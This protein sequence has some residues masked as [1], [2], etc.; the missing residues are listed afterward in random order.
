MNNHYDSYD[1]LL[2]IYLGVTIPP[3]SVN[4]SLNGVAQFTCTGVASAFVWKENGIQTN[5]TNITQHNINVDTVSTI[6]VQGSS[7]E[8]GTNITCTAVSLVP[9]SVDESEPATLLVQGRY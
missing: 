4:I 2:Y 7:F 5:S 1:S 6:E 3:Q 8:N 9:L